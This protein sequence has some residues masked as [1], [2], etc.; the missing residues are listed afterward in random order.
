MSSRADSPPDPGQLTTYEIRIKGQLDPTW[1]DW[2]PGAGH[3][4]A[5][6]RRHTVGWSGGRS[7]RAARAIAK[8]SRPGLASRLGQSGRAWQHAMSHLAVNQRSRGRGGGSEMSSSITERLTQNGVASV[9]GGCTSGLIVASVLAD[10]LGHIGW[11]EPGRSIRRPRARPVVPGRT[12]RRARL[13]AALR[14]GRLGP[15]RSV[16]AVNQE[17]GAAVPAAQRRRCRDPV[18]E[19]AAAGLGDA[20]ERPGPTCRP[21]RR[22]SSPGLGRCRRAPTRQASSRPSCSSARGCSR[23]A[24][25]STSPGSCRGSSASSC[26]STASLC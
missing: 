4:A 26:C 19:H 2:F 6:E 14:P 3:H 5:G 8:G 11:A 13:G 22:H 23:S 17:P 15:L 25:S 1:G 20:A 21:S 10:R 9:T 16:A 18:R 24:T 7:G 12:R